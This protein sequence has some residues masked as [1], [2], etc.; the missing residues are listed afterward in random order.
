M[1]G[2]IL[3]VESLVSGYKEPVV[4]PISFRLEDG[5]IVGLA[6]PNGAGKST[7][8]GALI[9]K[10]RIFS[11]SVRRRPGIRVGI[12]SQAPVRLTEMPVTGSDFLHIT[13]AD[14]HAVPEPLQ[15]LLPKR[16]DLLSGGQ[17][18]LMNVWA[19][20]GCAAEL[21]LLD[22][23]TNNMDPR[24]TTTLVDVLHASQADGRG[25]LVISHEHDFLEQVCTRVVEVQP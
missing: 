7:V 1:S 15:P 11:G 6:G 17:Y 20:L 14:R 8:L 5:E 4:G 13:G 25:V 23:P 3:E 18:Q 24:A 2:P 16:L 22:E 9:G 10:T 12:Q 19:C 21:V